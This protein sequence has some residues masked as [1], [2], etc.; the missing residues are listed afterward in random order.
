ML[1]SGAYR[2]A[3]ES[4]RI[5]YGAEKLNEWSAVIQWTILEMVQI[6]VKF[7]N[8]ICPTANYFS[9]EFIWEGS[10]VSIVNTFLALHVS[11]KLITAHKLWSPWLF[12]LAFPIFS[13]ANFDVKQIYNFCHFCCYHNSVWSSLNYTKVYEEKCKIG[14]FSEIL[15]KCH[16]GYF[17]NEKHKDLVSGHKNASHIHQELNGALFHILSLK[18]F[19][20]I[21]NIS[22]VY[23]SFAILCQVS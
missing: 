7:N 1:F 4:K 23:P 17:D 5:I 10:N 11:L 20:L 18:F 16:R 3:K 12:K 19:F 14:Q 9:R 21:F 15:K 6:W 2:R 13:S 8:L 22:W